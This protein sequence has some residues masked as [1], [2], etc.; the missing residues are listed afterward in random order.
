VIWV[1]Q[2]E[3]DTA[4]KLD[5]FVR[6]LHRDGWFIATEAKNG[7]VPPSPALAE[8]HTRLPAAQ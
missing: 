1:R 4:A 2:G 6:D 7:L 8:W 3:R 5:T